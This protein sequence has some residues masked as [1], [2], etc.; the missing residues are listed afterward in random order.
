MQRK[1]L[2]VITAALSVIFLGLTSV[3]S[4]S[5]KEAQINGKP[6]TA[7]QDAIENS[8]LIPGP[9]GEVGLMGPQGPQGATG[10]DG[11]SCWDLNGNYNNDAEEDINNDGAW[12]ALDCQPVGNETLPRFINYATDNGPND[13]TDFGIIKSRRLSFEKLRG[14]SDIRI[15]Y[16]DTFRTRGNSK[17]CRWEIL[18]DD[19]SCPSQLLVYDNYVSQGNYHR[20]GTLV[21]Y[22]SGL[23]TGLHEIQIH[24]GNTPGYT[25]SDCYTGWN[26]STW[27]IEAEEVN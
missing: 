12:D 23:D 20:S 16:T 14:N 11:L 1:I 19:T 22:C 7:L 17:A 27:V 25:G 21:G 26:S 2:A 13:G 24:V 10:W 8:K 4:V 15:S 5:A 3:C 9:Q 18:I 6:F